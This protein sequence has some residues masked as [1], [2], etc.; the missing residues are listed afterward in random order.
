MYN[1]MSSHL[2]ATELADYLVTKGLPFRQA[3]ELVGKVVQISIETDQPLWS[4]PLVVY[5]SISTLFE[6]DVHEWLDFE[7]AVERRNGPGGTAKAAVIAQIEALRL[8]LS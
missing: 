3:H 1:A 7:K 6:Q 5:Q 8:K 4:L 2:L